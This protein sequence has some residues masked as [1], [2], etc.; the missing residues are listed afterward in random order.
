[1]AFL[2]GGSLQE[3][4]EVFTTPAIPPRCRARAHGKKDSEIETV[5][6]ESTRTPH[7]GW[8]GLEEKSRDSNPNWDAR[9]HSVAAKHKLS[10]TIVLTPLTP[11][12][13]SFI[14]L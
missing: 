8:R 3:T 13:I 9:Q 4:C 5:S 7:Q 2:W 14:P 12:S 11:V 1:M 6:P 10:E